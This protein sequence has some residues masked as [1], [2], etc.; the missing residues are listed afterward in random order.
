MTPTRRTGN[1]VQ[2]KGLA[3]QRKYNLTYKHAPKCNLNTK[4]Q[5]KLKKSTEFY[6]KFILRFVG[7]ILNRLWSRRRFCWNNGRVF[8]L[9]SSVLVLRRRA[10]L[11]KLYF[12]RLSHRGNNARGWADP[13]FTAPLAETKHEVL[14]CSNLV[15]MAFL[16]PR[17]RACM[18]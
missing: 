4:T 9:C 6:L 1:S 2:N 15:F 17:V 11:R 5:E 8:S 16:H 18:H 10:R 13:S 3:H 14:F 7:I 12:S